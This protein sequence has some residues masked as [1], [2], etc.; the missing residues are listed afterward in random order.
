MEEIEFPKFER[1]K[2]E[3]VT[4]LTQQL[5]DFGEWQVTRAHLSEKTASRL[6]IELEV[7]IDNKET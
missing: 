4:L 3:G 6:M 2:N 1:R 5:D 7:A